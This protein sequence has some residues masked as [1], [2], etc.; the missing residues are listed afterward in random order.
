MFGCFSYGIPA[1]NKE[2]L[3]PYGYIW[4]SIEELDEETGESKT[5]SLL[6]SRELGI[7]FFYLQQAESTSQTLSEVAFGSQGASAFGGIGFGVIGAIGRSILGTVNTGGFT[8]AASKLVFHIC[9]SKTIVNYSIDITEEILQQKYQN[10]LYIKLPFIVGSV[11]AVT[12]SE[13]DFSED[14]LL[15]LGSTVNNRGI[16]GDIYKSGQVN[17]SLDI[18]QSLEDDN[19]FISR[20]LDNRQYAYRSGNKLFSNS[21]RQYVFSETS[22]IAFLSNRSDRI[23]SIVIRKNLERISILSDSASSNDV[24]DIGEIQ[25]DIGETTISIEKVQLPIYNSNDLLSSTILINNKDFSIGDSIYITANVIDTDQRKRR[26]AIEHKSQLFEESGINLLTDVYPV[27]TSVNAWDFSIHN[28]AVKKN[29][30]LDDEDLRTQKIAMEQLTNYNAIDVI[31][32][33]RLSQINN[34]DVKYMFIGESFGISRLAYVETQDLSE[35][36]VNPLFS[37]VIIPASELNGKGWWNKYKRDNLDNDG[38][39]VFNKNDIRF[40]GAVFDN[41]YAVNSLRFDDEKIPYFLPLA[42]AIQNAEAPLGFCHLDLYIKSHKDNN[43]GYITDEIANYSVD[44]YS[45]LTINQADGTAYNIDMSQAVFDIGQQSSYVSQK[46]GISGGYSASPCDDLED[47]SLAY[48]DPNDFRNEFDITGILQ[49]AGGFPDLTVYW[50]L[51]LPFYSDGYGRRTRVFVESFRTS[52][53][54][55]KQ[56]ACLVKPIGKIP[57]VISADNTYAM[58]NSFIFFIDNQQESLAFTKVNY[59]FYSSRSGDITNDFSLNNLTAF[60]FD[61]SRENTERLFPCGYNRIFGDSPGFSDGKHI[62]LEKN[63]LCDLNNPLN[64]V[65]NYNNFYNTTSTVAANLGNGSFSVN[66]LSDIMVK[67]I[68]LEISVNSNDSGIDDDLVIAFDEEDKRLIENISVPSDTGQYTYDIELG[69]YESNGFIKFYCPS[70]VNNL[71]V[72][73]TYIDKNDFDTYKINTTAMSSIINNRNHMFVFFVTEEDNI[74]FLHSTDEGK[75]WNNYYDLIR[76]VKGETASHPYAVY[77][78]KSN[79][80][81]LFYVLNNIF[82]MHKVIYES[83]INCDDVSKYIDRHESWSFDSNND[84]LSEFS[85]EG[86]KMRYTAGEF[87]CGDKKDKFY[88][89]MKH[90]DMK[91]AEYNKKYK[92]DDSFIKKYT[93][94]SYADINNIDFREDLNREFTSNYLYFAIISPNGGLALFYVVDGLLNIKMQT[95]YP[96]V[97]FNILGNIIFHAN[98]TED[99][100]DDNGE[101][102]FDGKLLTS[103]SGIVNYQSEDIIL[104]YVYDGMLFARRFNILQLFDTIGKLLV[105][106]SSNANIGN[107]NSA[108]GV[109]VSV[110]GESL[111]SGLIAASSDIVEEIIDAVVDTVID[112]ADYISGYITI[113]GERISIIKYFYPSKNDKAIFLVG[114]MNDKIKSTID[115]NI[116]LISYNYNTHVDVFDEL[117]INE[118]AK[119][120]GVFLKNGVLKFFYFNEDNILLSGNLSADIPTLDIFF[121]NKL[122]D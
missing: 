12:K 59:G 55:E 108:S 82:L 95:Y 120:D 73:Y 96:G 102:V 15:K 32:G 22:D 90:I 83:D 75:N 61:I 113:L 114:H 60:D 41:S 26:Q 76:L 57:Q 118:Y 10:N 70:F 6:P 122:E 112:I 44:D 111:I 84:D 116:S 24:V 47:G 71:N 119:N 35:I 43:G 78:P 81:H 91:R 21:N 27:N 1:Y 19:L 97:W 42:E 74:G 110:E 40:P 68:K 106:I 33:W 7:S 98:T 85:E 25:N 62:T 4:P 101:Y 39:L 89:D 93:R 48:R 49:T 23:S 28:F 34:W 105:A 3:I 92:D 53:N 86:K 50:M 66:T 99:T 64:T 38:I 107:N 52:G 69:Y 18:I 9:E 5:I 94:F 63:A 46:Q 79:D 30:N 11:L 88:Q 31:E 8:N 56:S 2:D 36:S 65:D 103:F 20:C 67:H 16:V 51:Y 117:S 72:E 17:S 77:D 100:N 54:V 109:G 80:V 37:E 58:D 29:M 104:L 14:D 121:V 13:I 45:K 115:T 87:V